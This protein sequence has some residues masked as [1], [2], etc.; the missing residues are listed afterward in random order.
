[1]ALL[2]DS[3]RRLL[4]R[5]TLP[6]RAR[7]TASRQGGH[8]S[9][10]LASGLEFAD[11]RPYVPGDD[12]RHIDWKAFARH[13]QLTIRQFEEERDARVY[14]LLDVSGSMTRGA[15]RARP[16]ESK[17]ELARRLASA[18][19]YLATRQFDAV[20]VVPFAAT[21]HAPSPRFARREEIA[22]VE[23]FVAERPV[24]DMTSFGA[25]V[26]AF[27]SRFPQRGLV[28]LVSDLMTPDGWEEG[29]RILGGLGHEVRVFRVTCEND[30][31]PD[32]RGELDLIDSESNERLQVRAH[33]AL[34]AAYA[35]VLREH[36]ARITSAARATGGDL[37]DAPVETPIASIVK[38]AFRAGRRAA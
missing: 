5:L 18:V 16:G 4:D 35:E 12:V 10:A 22:R 6:V 29:I 32:F 14:V 19:A 1:M 37:V 2:D 27:A 28:V 21:A 13:R 36:V 17:I 31:R 38:T 30:N 20:H 23:S 33:P 11:H 8:R 24:G 9:K 3:L 7:S 26:R 15:T 34:L 25:S